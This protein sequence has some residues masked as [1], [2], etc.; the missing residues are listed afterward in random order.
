MQGARAQEAF[1]RARAIIAGTVHTSANTAFI[2]DRR[3]KADTVA[4]LIRIGR[5]IGQATRAHIALIQ[6]GRAMAITVA[7]TR[8]FTVWAIT[9]TITDIR[10]VES[11]CATHAHTTGRGIGKGGTS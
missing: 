6:E 5:V 11:R 4:V 9:A 1:I 10:N 7:I 8:F 3:A 2:D